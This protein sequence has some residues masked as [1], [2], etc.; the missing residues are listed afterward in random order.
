MKENGFTLS[1]AR[2][3]RCPAQTITDI[4]NTDD[5]ALLAN[6]PIQAQSL[7]HSLEQAADGTGLHIK[8][9][10]TEY[11]C[12]N[13]KGDNSTLNGGSLK[14]ADIFPFLGRSISSTENN[15]NTRL[16]KAWTAINRLLVIW[17]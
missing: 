14:L 15:I 17:K 3:R 1:K 9:D 6:I 16:A 10:K 4:D 2:S 11:M 7:Q 13:Q 8:V 5:I 12:F